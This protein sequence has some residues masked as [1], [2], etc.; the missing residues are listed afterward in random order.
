MKFWQTIKFKT[1]APVVVIVAGAFAAFSYL[2]AADLIDS[3]EDAFHAEIEL[4]TELS[5]QA[6]GNA[7]W[8][9]NQD[10][11]KTVLQPLTDNGHFSWA[12]VREENG[13]IFTTVAKAAVEGKD[14]LALLPAEAL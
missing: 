14:M 7:I 1:I 3:V 13:S 5:N 10:L 2:T 12:V 11:A 8:D 4:S 6:L 9:F